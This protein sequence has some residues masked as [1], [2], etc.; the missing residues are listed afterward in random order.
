MLACPLGVVVAG[1]GE[2]CVETR[3]PVQVSVDGRAPATCASWVLDVR[4]C[5]TGGSCEGGCGACIDGA[6]DPEC[7]PIDACDDNTLSL[8]PGDY[9]V[10]VHAEL[11]NGGISFDGCTD[12]SVPEKGDPAAVPIAVDTDDA[13]PCIRDWTFNGSSCCNTMF[14]CVPPGS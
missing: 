6:P 1:C 14:G 13:F 12:A 7:E 4:A 2:E 5:S 10:C 11:V 8:S 3:V 9:R